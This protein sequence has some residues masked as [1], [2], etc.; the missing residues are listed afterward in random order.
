MN[1]WIDGHLR[2][3][4]VPEMSH[5]LRELLKWACLQN[6]CLEPQSCTLRPG[7]P[8]TSA[9][10]FLYYT[11]WVM[12]HFIHC[13]ADHTFSKPGLLRFYLIT[14]WSPATLTVLD[15]SVMW[16]SLHSTG[17]QAHPFGKDT[18][19]FPERS[20]EPQCCQSQMFPC[21]ANGYHALQIYP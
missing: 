15:T 14:M 13:F 4:D 8:L 9:E 3:S 7:S 5:N 17:H 6:K 19:P 1:E 21:A 10:C 18:T 16:H 12:F 20:K 11:G 2:R